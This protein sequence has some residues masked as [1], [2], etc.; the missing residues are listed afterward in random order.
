[1]NYNFY[2]NSISKYKL[3]NA[4]EEK[5]LA[6]EIRDGNLKSKEKMINSNLRLVVYIAKKYTTQGMDFND[7]I[8]EGNIGLIRSVEKFDP[9]LGFRFSTYAVLW[10]RQ[11]IDLAVMN[12]KDLVRK[13]VYITKKIRECKKAER[14]FEEG[15]NLKPT[16]KKIAEHI[17]Y[18]EE[19]VVNLLEI[20]NRNAASLDSD[21]VLLHEVEAENPLCSP[22]KGVID[23]NFNHS[24][25]NLMEFLSDKQKLILIHRF[26][27]F[28]ETPKTL[29]E[30]SEIISLTRERVRQIQKA[31]LNIIK[32]NMSS[33]EIDTIY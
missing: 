17:G 3:L 27:L 15:V 29:Q 26:G 8:S 32:N 31:S 28:N 18:T 22:E 19:E 20:S 11:A 10:I 24:I 16:A 9:D 2:L 1:M 4:E 25:F 7:L 6:Y 33:Y 12:Q 14:Y 5:S 30:V 13:P 23:D 21:S